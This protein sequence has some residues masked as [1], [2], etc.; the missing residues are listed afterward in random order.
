MFAQIRRRWAEIFGANLYVRTIAPEKVFS[1][2]KSVRTECNEDFST[3]HQQ[4]N[5]Y[6]IAQ[7]WPN[8][9]NRRAARQIAPTSTA[10]QTF[11][12]DLISSAS[13]MSEMAI[14]HQLK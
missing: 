7:S 4:R 2:S 5:T 3:T 8:T 12:F 10:H 1:P 6:P 14:S 13:M 11:L 9:A